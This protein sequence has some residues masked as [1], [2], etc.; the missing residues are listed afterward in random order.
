MVWWAH[1]LGNFITDLFNNSR[2]HF[3]AW[4]E[5]TYFTFWQKELASCTAWYIEVVNTVVLLKTCFVFPSRKN[6]VL[7]V[8][9]VT[10]KKIVMHDIY[11]WSKMSFIIMR[12][13]LKGVNFF[14]Y[15]TVI[16]AHGQLGM[17]IGDVLMV[18]TWWNNR[19][20]H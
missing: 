16:Y 7:T 2:V 18:K 1:E 15:Q 6:K 10:G 13:F 8:M 3:A 20:N 9:L 19:E 17:P 11:S 4:R 14:Q 5:V 12:L